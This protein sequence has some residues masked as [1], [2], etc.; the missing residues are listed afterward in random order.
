LTMDRMVMVVVLMSGMAILI[1]IAVIILLRQAAADELFVRVQSVAGFGLAGPGAAPKPRLSSMVGILHRLGERI[2]NNRSLYSEQD[3]AALEDVLVASGFK[4]RQV[5]PI[6]LGGKVAF[7][8]LVVA[9]AILYGFVGNLS[10]VQRIMAIAIACPVGFM[11]PEIVLRLLRRPYVK[12]VERGVADALDLLVVCSEAGMGL[13]SG[14]HEV[15]LEMRHTNPAISATLS[16]LLDELRVLPDRRQAFQNFGRRSGVEG[17]R[18]LAT[19]LG[20][21]LQYG[22]PLGQALRSMANELRRERMTQLEAKA[23]RLPALLVFPLIAF[24]MPSLFIAL[25]GPTMLR[26]LDTLNATTTHVGG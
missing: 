25:M 22:T 20:Q 24:I 10:S 7:L 3:I 15:M 23:I 26:L 9:G 6:I 14:L 16:I 18:R 2:G 17:V 13:E 12:A 8:V 21:T 1:G 5:L 19:I 4:S 11:G